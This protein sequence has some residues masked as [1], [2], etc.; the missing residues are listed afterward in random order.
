MSRT[1]TKV[2]LG[3]SALA[4][5]A[6]ADPKI[7][8]KHLRMDFRQ[9]AVPPLPAVRALMQQCRLLCL[10]EQHD[11]AGRYLSAELVTAA[12]QAGARTLFV[13]VYDHEQAVIDEFVRSGLHE[14]LPLSAGGGGAVPMRFQLPYVQMMHAARDAGLQ[15]VAIDRDGLQ[16]HERDEHM[17]ESI[18]AHLSK[19]PCKAVAIAGQLHLVSRLVY[20]RGMSMAS[21]LRPWLG[22]DLVT[23]GRAVPDDYPEFSIWSDVA[24]VKKPWLLPTAE[25]AWFELPYTSSDGSFCCG[26]FDHV[27]FYPAQAVL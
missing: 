23:V 1:V 2:D 4:A 15:I 24:A 19:K 3:L 9:L 5:L 7:S 11:F 26:D 8:L 20:G 21:H 17:A 25:S 22:H 18:R 12:A 13:E 10:G 27:L 16:S 14:F 6:H